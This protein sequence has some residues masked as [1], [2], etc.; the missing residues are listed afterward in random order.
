MN[1]PV[2]ERISRSLLRLDGPGSFCGYHREPGQ[3]LY[4]DVDGVG[5]CEVPI[6]E[7]VAEALIEHATPSPFGYRDQTRH[8]PSV[9]DSWEIP[10]ERVR[11]DPRV[12]SRRF[13]RG[14]RE[15]TEA[16]GFPPSA[17][18]TPRLQKLLIYGT[19]QFFAPHRDTEKNATTWGTLVV[20]LP[21]AYR[22]GEVVIS[23][24]GQRVT[25]DT[26]ADAAQGRVGF[27][28]LYADC[29]H[30]TK[31]VSRGHRIALTYALDVETSEQAPRPSDDHLDLRQSVVG[32]FE[33]AASPAHDSP[34]DV[35]ER[36]LVV[37]LD[38]EYSPQG[39]EWA[40]LKN[41]DRTRVDALR[42]VAAS[43]DCAC[44]LAIADVHETY[45]IDDE[46]E[47]TSEGQGIPPGGY[48][49]LTD[50]ELSLDRWID[51]QGRPCV[52]T[53]EVADERCVVATV[54]SHQRAAYE[55]SYSPWTGNEGGHADQWYHQAA[56]VIV[57][58]DQ[59]LH[60]EICR[61]KTSPGQPRGPAR[62]S[63]AVR[64]RKKRDP[65]S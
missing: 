55:R 28:G 48:G 32:Y 56:L 46:S 1:N 36:W 51:D 38:H 52:G 34:A 27:L 63:V 62:S 20:L 4:L 47:S 16:L 19:G 42:E 8:D 30:E 53:T 50:R 3:G 41:S 12:W 37:L 65:G 15:V 58:R 14:V 13:E 23:H 10:G 44:F 26:A 64:R 9:R 22:G 25:Y 11:L 61:V 33:A 40:R 5:R 18:V 43:L 7:R 49:P 21:S 2:L 31:P 39:L 35:D 57:P 45:S 59:P 54:D 24:A 29:V 60:E 6:A 17:K